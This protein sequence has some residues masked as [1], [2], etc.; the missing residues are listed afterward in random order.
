MDRE[1]AKLF[2]T[3]CLG[4]VRELSSA[5]AFTQ[6]PA[7]ESTDMG[8]K[9]SIADIVARIDGLLADSIYARFPDL[10]DLQK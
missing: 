9:R 8:I 10:D 5:L 7:S 1:T 3:H 6:G 4:A 2:R